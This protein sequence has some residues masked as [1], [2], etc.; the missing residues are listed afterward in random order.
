MDKGRE[1]IKKLCKHIGAQLVE[2]ADM[3]EKSHCDI[4]GELEYTD[5]MLPSHEPNNSSLICID[6]SA[7]L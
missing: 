2:I 6:C 7:K 4:C 1:N 3:D 5:K